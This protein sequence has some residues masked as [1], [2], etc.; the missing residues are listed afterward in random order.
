[1]SKQTEDNV[2]RHG[3][4]SESYWNGN[5]WVRAITDNDGLWTS[6]YGAGELMRYASLKRDQVG[7]QA[8]IQQARK[9]ALRSLKAVLLIS[10]VSGRKGRVNAK[11]RH[12]NNTRTQEGAFYE[13]E[14][15]KKGKQDRRDVYPGRPADGIGFFGLDAGKVVEDDT[16]D[17]H[18]RYSL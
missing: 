3:L 13:P 12:L 18:F 1:M 7:T 14:F 6:M 11:I 4:A 10:N 15:L 17:G 5:E 8:E 2:M 9:S 16:R